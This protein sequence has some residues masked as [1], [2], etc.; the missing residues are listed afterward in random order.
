MEEKISPSRIPLL[1]PISYPSQIATNTDHNKQN[2]FNKE[3]PPAATATAC[4][5]LIFGPHGPRHACVGCPVGFSV[6]VFAG[7]VDDVVVICKGGKIGVEL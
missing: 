5:G 6:Q 2:K 4:A 1:C 3:P 7:N